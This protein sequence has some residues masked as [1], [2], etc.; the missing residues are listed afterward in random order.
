L[1]AIF[2]SDARSL[3]FSGDE[4][5]DKTVLKDFVAAYS[6]MHRWVEIKAG[7]QLLVIGADNYPF[8][9]PLAKNPSGQWYFDTA[10]GKDEILARRIGKNE[11]AAIALCMAAAEA[12]QKY[13]GQAHDGGKA[14][15]FAQRFA[16]DEGKQNGLY[17]TVSEGQSP[18]PLGPIGDFAKS[19]GYTGSGDK[20]Q[21]FNGYY[22]RI[23][24]KQGDKAEGGAKDYV[25]NGQMTGGFAIVAYLAEYRNSG[26]MTFMAGEDCKVYQKDLGEKT[27][28]AAAALTEY[29]PGDGWTPAI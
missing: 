6:Q 19:M 2:G 25:V 12:Q 4:I 27:A 24:T 13:Y 8:P 21:P 10:A 5:K 28:D 18:S 11:L 23:L 15:Q 22:F 16:S 29:N 7:D 14:G 26:I 9:I 1:L 3:L 20:P 17:W